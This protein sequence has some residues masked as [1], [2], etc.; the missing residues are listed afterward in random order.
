MNA[1]TL[2]SQISAGH[3]DFGRHRQLRQQPIAQ[4][5][6]YEIRCNR[7]IQDL[8]IEEAAKIAKRR[9]RHET[10]PDQNTNEDRRLEAWQGILDCMDGPM[11]APELC[12]MLDR[13]GSAV[14]NSL[15]KM[16]EQGLVT[17]VEQG[18]LANGRQLPFLWS[19]VEGRPCHIANRVKGEKTRTTVY[20]K[21]TGP[22]T[23]HDIAA[24]TGLR[25]HTVQ[26]VMREMERQGR[27]R[28]A[29]KG[30]KVNGKGSAPTLWVRT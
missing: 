19:R 25:P 29:G 20:E 23:A 5:T 12:L 9:P 27:V 4:W 14:S 7:I 11:T 18:R 30:P 26:Q 13:S 16:E 21:L 8:M 15:R 6:E 28:R 1:I 24:L 17:H 2:H 10:L 3:E 22:A